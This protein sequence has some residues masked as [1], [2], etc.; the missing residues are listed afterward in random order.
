MA[1]LVTGAAGFIG[2]HT[3]QALLSRGDHVIGIDNMNDYY[4]ISLKKA[5]LSKLEKYTNFYG[6]EL[7]FS[8]QKILASGLKGLGIERIIHLGAQAG[9]RYSIENP[10]AYVHSNLIGHVNM[11]ELSRQL[12]DFKHFVYASSSSVYGGN[13]IIPFSERHTT[14]TPLSLYAATKKSNELLSQSYAHLYRTPMTGLRFFT[15]YGNWGRPD[16]AYWLF[17]KFII[18]GKP[19][20]VFNNGDMRRDFTH[21]DDIVSGIIACLDNPPK[22]DGSLYIDESTAPHRV[23]NIGSNKSECLLGMI[24]I[25]EDSLGMKA[26]KVY[27]PM[28]SGDVKETFADIS[29]IKAAIGYSPSVKLQ[30]GLPQFVSWYRK[31][32]KM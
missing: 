11:L 18:E 4:D 22:D 24:E 19:I 2:M 8:D 28:Q 17:T 26:E 20:S 1:I 29:S 27:H 16:M 12:D 32:Y 9:V 30:D 14:N 5:R 31:F 13:M 7:D 21:I 15:V 23:F 25:I 10:N 6:F 3:C